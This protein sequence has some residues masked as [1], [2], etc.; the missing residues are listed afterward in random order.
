MDDL[1]KRIIEIENSAKTVSGTVESEMD[2]IRREAKQQWEK[3]RDEIMEKANAK[4]KSLEEMEQ[5]DT[6]KKIG[7][8]EKE[9]AEK[10]EK[11]EAAFQKNRDSWVQQV[12]ESIV[13]GAPQS[14]QKE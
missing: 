8:S 4:V 3:M 2:V 14:G 1:I 11:L 9:F 13:A 10:R 12:F 7:A 5:E 6:Q